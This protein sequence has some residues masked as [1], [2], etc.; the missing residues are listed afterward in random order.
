MAPASLVAADPL[1]LDVFSNGRTTH[2]VGPDNVDALGDFKYQFIRM[3]AP[4]F[5]A[6]VVQAIDAI[7]DAIA[8]LIPQSVRDWIAATK[9]A[10]FDW[11]LTKAFGKNWDQI[12]D[13]FL[14]PPTVAEIVP[15]EMTS[16][17]S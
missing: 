10:V 7:N 11:I 17:K 15:L 12:K 5:V 4:D 1:H 9:R 3:L 13:A 8:S 16:A 14:M 6:S 2:I